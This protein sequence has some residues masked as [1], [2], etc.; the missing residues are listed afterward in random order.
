MKKPVLTEVRDCFGSPLLRLGVAF[1]VLRF[2]GMVDLQPT[3]EL[4][5]ACSQQLD[6]LKGGGGGGGGA[7]ETSETV[8]REVVRSKD[9]GIN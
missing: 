7:G 8:R 1:L 5:S 9:Q 3:V 4:L 2:P 6:I